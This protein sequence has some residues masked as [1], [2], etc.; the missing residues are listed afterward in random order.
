MSDMPRV[1]RS[2]VDTV[3]EV[4]DPLTPTSVG[5]AEVVSVEGDTVT[6]TIGDETVTG[7][8]LQ[9][10]TPA[11][12]D[13]VEVESRGDLLVVPNLWEVGVTDGALAIVSDAEPVPEG[14]EVAAGGTDAETFFVVAGSAWEIRSVPDPDQDPTSNVIQTLFEVYGASVDPGDVVPVGG[15]AGGVRGTVVF[16]VAPGDVIDV[17]AIVSSIE[18]D[19]ALVRV[20]VRYGAINTADLMSDP[21]TAP[22]NTSTPITIGATPSESTDL[23]VDAEG[24]EVSGS[25]TVPA[26]TTIGATTIIPAHAVVGL[27]FAPQAGTVVANP[28]LTVDTLVVT[29]NTGEFPL[30]S[31]WVDPGGEMGG[32]ATSGPVGVGQIT[33]QSMPWNGGAWSGLPGS[34][35]VKIQAPPGQ[36]GLLLLFAS[37]NFTG[38]GD[39]IF[40][41]ACTSPDWI[42]G[43]GNGVRS[44]SYTR[45]QGI[46]TGSTL[47]L[48]GAIALD[49]GEVV[50]AWIEYLYNSNPGATLASA[51][52]SALLPVFLPGGVMLGGTADAP[53]SMWDGDGWWPGELDG[54]SGDLDSLATD[55]LASLTA[56]ATAVA[57]LPSAVKKGQSVTVTATITGGGSIGGTA[58][59]YQGDGGGAWYPIGTSPVVGGVASRVW[60]A[61][62]L[63]ARYFRVAYSGSAVYAASVGVSASAVTVTS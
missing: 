34:R 27:R 63:G 41:L 49:P 12:G 56:T 37:S 51:R 20:N 55:S 1:P 53:F 45:V 15:Y 40:R 33:P 14:V 44:T 10:E 9:G 24:V 16:D 21:A 4:G 47:V 19:P 30:G 3:V 61:S 8:V 42:V 52:G 7:V 17:D 59:F 39:V 62:V 58:T 36:G 54:A 25:F 57:F 13:V 6:V 32:S 50:Y 46:T 2:R 18:G 43:S 35:R 11:V 31:L 22:A 38:T 5:A 29:R 60:V 23:L 26:T 28:L 48:Y